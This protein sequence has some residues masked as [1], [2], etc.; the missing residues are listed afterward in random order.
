MLSQTRLTLNTHNLTSPM[1]QET[2]P[3]ANLQWK[4]TICTSSDITNASIVEGGEA[5]FDNF[6][7]T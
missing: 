7:T 5:R 6:Y 2:K 3:L 4:H 1:A